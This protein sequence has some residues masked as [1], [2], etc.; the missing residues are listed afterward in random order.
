VAL[1]AD[2]HRL[3]VGAQHACFRCRVRYI[4]AGTCPGCAGPLV[5]LADP[6]A[7]PRLVR[8]ARRGRRARRGANTEHADRAYALI[9]HLVAIGCALAGGYFASK[10]ETRGFVSTWVVTAAGAALGFAGGYLLTALCSVALLLLAAATAGAVSAVTV[11]V[12]LI[13]LGAWML[14]GRRGRRFRDGV[15]RATA[16]ILRA[17]FAPVRVLRGM[18]V[19]ARPAKPRETTGLLPDAAPRTAGEH[20]GNA[21]EGVLLESCG[22]V[23]LASDLSGAIVGAEGTTLGATLADALVAPLLLRTDAGE[24]VRVE[25]LVGEVRVAGPGRAILLGEGAPRTWGVPPRPPSRRQRRRFPAPQTVT[26]WVV[27]PGARVR[28]EGGTTAEEAVAGETDSYRANRFVRVV[29][30]SVEAPVRVKLL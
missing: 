28:V 18:P 26:A 3:I 15:E 27:E 20:T 12:A 9:A 1:A 22:R 8:L 16:A 2:L 17:A 10:I 4:R 14:A 29:R 7:A 23:A 6:E 25:V 5:D 13:L 19:T 30:G 21:I 11:A 24:L